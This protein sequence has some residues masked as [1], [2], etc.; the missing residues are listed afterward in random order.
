M[1]GSTRNNRIGKICVDEVN[2]CSYC[3]RTFKKISTLM[4]HSCEEG[5][6]NKQKNEQH[7]QI[8]LS[9]FVKFF[10]KSLNQIKTYD[11]FVK[12]QYYLAFVRFG[13]YVKDIHCANPRAYTDWLINN[14]IA[15]DK[16]TTDKN[17]DLFLRNWI[18]IEN[19]MDAADRSFNSII[20]WADSHKKDVSDYFTQATNAYIV[21][22]ISYAKVSP[23]IVYC[24]NSGAD[25]LAKTNPEELKIMWAMLDPDRWQSKLIKD[26]SSKKEITELCR[27]VGL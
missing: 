20:E 10:K 27:E 25:W 13:H 1:V 3:D 19:H 14:N 11:D 22:D 17:Y 9:A 7:V 15:L 24:S 21:N 2:K 6:R 8:G 23:W 5:R 16:W 12:S 18:F 4:V 26:V